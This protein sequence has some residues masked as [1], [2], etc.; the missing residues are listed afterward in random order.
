MDWT[1]FHQL[2]RDL[3]P[4]T[5]EETKEEHMRNGLSASL[6]GTA[7]LTLSPS[8]VLAQ[9]TAPASPA[10]DAAAPSAGGIATWWWVLLLAVVIAAAVWY[11]TRKRTTP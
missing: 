9:T 3:P 2:R 11:F 10:G 8:L 1:T 6:A 5:W 4:L 7:L